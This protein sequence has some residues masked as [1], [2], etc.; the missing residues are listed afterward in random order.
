MESDDSSSS[1]DASLQLRLLGALTVS[2]GGRPVP[3]PSSRKVRAL[4]AYL[5]LSPRPVARSQLCE[6]L[7]DVPNDPRGE[8]R[9]SLSKLRGIVDEPGCRRVVAVRCET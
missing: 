3:L 4:L 2:R 5:A 7:W 1:G 6:L 8:L 9:W